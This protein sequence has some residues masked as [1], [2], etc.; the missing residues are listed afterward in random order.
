MSPDFPVKTDLPENFDRRAA[1]ERLDRVLDPE[2]DKSILKLG[3]V[4]SLRVQESHLTVV[5]YLPTYFC[6]PGFVYLMANDVR[7]ELLSVEGVQEVTVRLR[8]HFAAAAIET[9]VN[10]GRSFSEA[11]PGEALGNLDQLRS[12]F[13]RKGYLSRQDAFLRVLREAGLSWKQ[14]ADL[15]IEDVALGERSSFVQCPG[16]EPVELSAETT[17]RYLERRSQIGLDCSPSAPLL[18][19][20]NGKAIPAGRLEQHRLHARTVRVSLE[21]NGSLC[22]VLLEARRRQRAMG[23]DPDV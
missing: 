23:G 3:F 15:R 19:D 17:G 13:L 8:D 10:Q 22:S 7:R 16:D 2:L 14:I 11:F 4:E 5:L 18:T 20:L 6:A 12:L 1:L 9:G 21:A